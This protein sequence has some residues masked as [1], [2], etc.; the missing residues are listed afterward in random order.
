LQYS[1]L[2][3]FNLCFVNSVAVATSGALVR[4]VDISDRGLEADVAT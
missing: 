1:A 4:P 2:L 3:P